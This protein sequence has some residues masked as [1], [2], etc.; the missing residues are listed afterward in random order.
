[1]FKLVA[2]VLMVILAVW[3]LTHMNEENVELK[4]SVI[5]VGRELIDIGK[6]IIEE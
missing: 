5:H 1:M 6:R 3:I 4:E 2:Q